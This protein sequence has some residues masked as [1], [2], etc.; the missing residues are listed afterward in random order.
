MNDTANLTLALGA[1]PIMSSLAL[2]VA[3]L[4]SRIG[5]LVLN[6]GTL[7]VPQCEAHMQAGLAARRNGK[8]VVFDPVGVGAT[9]FRRST[10]D[11]EPFMLRWRSK[12]SCAELT[13]THRFSQSSAPLCT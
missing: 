10:A 8:A 2:E 3:E 7:S 9:S 13:G 11:G 6:L 12:K 4:S 1:S 5:A